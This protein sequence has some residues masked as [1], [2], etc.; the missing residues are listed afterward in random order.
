[1][2]LI[3]PATRPLVENR[4][5]VKRALL[6]KWAKDEQC[7]PGGLY[8]FVKHFWHVLEPKTEFKDGW[9]IQALCLHLEAIT[10]GTFQVPRLLA[11]VPPGF[12][13]SLLTN[14]FWPAWEWGPMNMPH[15]RT[16]SFS[17][18]AHLTQRDNGKFRDL[19]RSREYQALYGDRFKL[20][21]DGVEKVANDKTGWR[22]ASSVLGV[23]TG[24]RGD[25]AILDDPHNVKDGES[26][27][28][29]T[30]TVRWFDEA[31]SNR[32]NDLEKSAIVVI[33][34]RVNEADVSGHIIDHEPDYVHLM[35]AMEYDGR[36]CETPIWSDPRTKIGELAWPERYPDRTLTRFRRNP[37]MWAGQYQQTP[38]P[39]GGGLFKRDWW[40]LERVPIGSAPPQC[41]YIV[42]SLDSAY[43][44]EERNDPS[45]FTC[46][47]VYRDRN[48][49]PKILLLGAWRKHLE[50][51]GPH[52]ERKKGENERIY[53][54]RLRK[55]WGLVEWV[56]HDCR[57]LRVNKLLIE[58]KASGLSVAQEIQRLYAS[59]NWGV[60][61]VNPEGDKFARAVA[62]TH[63][64]ADGLVHVPA[65]NIEP[66]DKDSDLVPRDWAQLVIDETA[67]FPNGRFRDLTDSTTQ[68][69]KHL[70]E[71]GLAVRTEEREEERLAQSSIN[72]RPLP[73]YPT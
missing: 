3:V 54:D 14:V 60:E 27:T 2:G 59:K 29:R 31:M 50:L 8:A 57:R 51:H 24:E 16:I 69:L 32:L 63:L 45:G 12:M 1:M 18:A 71:I 21:A 56:A 15:L 41:D 62:I 5:A 13:K 28:V 38:E 39:R 49:N 30:K 64:F 35:I 47:G 70:R 33:M 19:V 65:S 68:A 58:S 10:L 48:D 17:Y 23:G 7:R 34:Q 11:N 9:A 46:W 42:A 37:Y 22:Y 55:S 6:R 61:M 43:T 26:E 52:V 25:R 53:Q 40:G 36:H 72:E 20:I 66:D 73:L 4:I 44:K 67:T